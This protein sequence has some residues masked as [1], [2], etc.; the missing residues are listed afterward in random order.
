MKLKNYVLLS[1]TSILT[2]GTTR[3]MPV[4]VETAF[5]SP[6]TM[7]RERPSFETADGETAVVDTR[8]IP[9]IEME[10]RDPARIEGREVPES[11]KSRNIPSI[12]VEIRDPARIEG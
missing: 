7:K 3:P 2:P 9:S 10:I 6:G 4:S 11:I 12:E 1:L 5:R 8:D